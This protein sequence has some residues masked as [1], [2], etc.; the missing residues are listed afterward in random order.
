MNW[1][2]GLELELLLAFQADCT[3]RW[4][5]HLHR[6]FRSSRGEPK[7]FHCSEGFRFIGSSLHIVGPVKP[8]PV[9]AMVP[10]T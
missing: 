9:S 8:I 2:E 1:E 5:M 10:V 4:G 6:S 3:V 7:C